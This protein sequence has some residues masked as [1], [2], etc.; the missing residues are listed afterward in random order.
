MIQI[1]NVHEKLEVFTHYNS[2]SKIR[3]PSSLSISLEVLPNHISLHIG[4]LA[5]FQ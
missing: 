5:Y 4:E 3:T 2:Y 1:E